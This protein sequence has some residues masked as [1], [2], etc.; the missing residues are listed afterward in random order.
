MQTRFFLLFFLVLFVSGS[1]LSQRN[2]S[3]TVRIGICADV[4]LPTMHDAEYRITTFIDSMKIAKPDFLVDMG[5]FGTPAPKYAPYF[6]I[7]NSYPGPRYHV[8]G[9]HEMDGGYT[10][11]QALAYRNMT[12][13]YYSFR[14]NGFHFIVLDGNDKKTPDAKGYQEHIG[15]Q[16]LEWLKTELTKT[17]DPIVIFS[18]QGLGKDGVDNSAEIRRLLEAHNQQA[19]RNKILVNF[20]GHIHYDR[21]EAI[22]GIWYVCINSMSYKWLGE[23]YGHIRYS[24]E[25]DK[26]FK[27]I[28]YTAPYKDPLFTVVEISTNGTIKISGKKSEWVGPDPWALGYPETDKPYIK[29]EIT[30]RVLRFKRIR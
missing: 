1:A 6:A 15:T 16:Q 3:N 23:E 29:P 17:T 18:H 20:Y 14:R 28:K 9:N 27:W 24:P 5:D 26:E 4:H 13:S 25:V 30:E 21:A 10:L 2:P 8:I 11:Q 7:W 19:K 12:S 22:N